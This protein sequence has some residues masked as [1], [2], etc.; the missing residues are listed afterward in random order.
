MSIDERWGVGDKADSRSFDTTTVGDRIV[1]LIHGEHPHSRRDNNTYARDPQSGVV[2]E[3]DGHR[4]LIDVRI[5]SNNYLKSSDLSGDQIRRS[6]NV[7]IWSDGTQVY[8][9]FHRDVQAA[10]LKAHHLVGVLSEH[11]SG[12]L[13][14]DERIRLSGRRVY[15]HDTPATI[16][17]LVEEQ[18]AVMIRI[19]PQDAQGIRVRGKEI[20]EDWEDWEDWEDRDGGYTVKDDVLSPHI[21]WW[22]NDDETRTR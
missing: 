16:T 12:W 3:F 4:R 20:T 5:E 21:W 13:S 6:V 1:E 10:C 15:Y 7:S 22:R 17:G 2:H 19:E 11:E 18:G 9:T 14:A 8:E